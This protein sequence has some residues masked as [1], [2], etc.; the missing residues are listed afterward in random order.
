MDM[1]NIQTNDFLTWI[2]EQNVTQSDS[3]VLYDD[4]ESQSSYSLP[5][6]YQPFDP[7]QLSHWMDVGRTQDFLHAA[8][9][10][11]GKVLDFG[12]G[13]GW[14]SLVLAPFVA[15]VVGVDSSKKRIMTCRENALRMN[16]SNASFVHYQ[17]GSPLPFPDESFDGVVAASSVEQCPN[18]KEILS[19]F[20][21]VLKPG[22]RLRMCYEGL[23]RYK[24]GQERDVWIFETKD[25]NCSMVVFL[26]DIPGE[27]V[28]Y[29]KIDLSISKSELKL[30]SGIV[31]EMGFSALTLAKLEE[32]KP[33]VKTI[34]SYTLMHPSCKTW[35]QWLKEAGFSR[36]K[37]THDAGSVAAA[38]FDALTP[39]ERNMDLSEVY[40]RIGAVAPWVCELQAPEDD[41]PM[42]LA[43][44]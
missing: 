42:I 5:V 23:S 11:G 24:N 40:E 38:M 19:E 37:P 12:P 15:E 22:G 7:Q 41:D 28:A 6:V 13:D 27:K 14:P 39:E 17:A 1:Q 32:L 16:L 33:Y 31:D 3:Q 20:Y 2:A 4:M 21:R 29:Y 36:V 43:I 9:I 18:P 34:F 8:K 25:N 35:V 44:K 26:R 10:S 30:K